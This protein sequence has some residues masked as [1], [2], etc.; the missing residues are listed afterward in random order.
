MI[1]L[2][3]ICINCEPRTLQA[4]SIINEWRNPQN[5]G[6]KEPQQP[7]AGWNAEKF[8]DERKPHNTKLTLIEGDMTELLKLLWQAANT[9]RENRRRRRARSVTKL[10]TNSEW[11][12][13]REVADENKSSRH[14]NTIKRNNCAWNKSFFFFLGS[15]RRAIYRNRTIN[16]LRVFPYVRRRLGE[17]FST[18]RKEIINL[19]R[20]KNKCL[21]KISFENLNE[22]YN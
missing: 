11:K 4:P 2:K 14:R 7:R 15:R 20:R 9:E 5:A 19:L 8:R 22:I 13:E 21:L 16:A 6:G 18:Q 10:L 17:L 12:I 3:V 1:N